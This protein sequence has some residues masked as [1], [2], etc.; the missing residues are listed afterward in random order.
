MTDF[1]QRI[2]DMQGSVEDLARKVPGFKGYFEKQDR[3]AADKLLR[4][5][6]SRMFG[7]QLSEFVRV[8]KKLVDGGGMKHMGKVQG[9]QTR[10]QTL[11]DKID[12]APRGYAG[13]FDSVKV[14]EQALASVYAFDNGLFVYHDQL[15]SGLKALVDVIG[16][17]GVGKVLDQLDD[18]SAEISNTFA[19]RVDVLQGLQPSV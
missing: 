2:V 12:S 5:K 3:R 14:D 10:L 6:L 11:I 4:A 13:L 19:R 15:A 9:I 18:L 8:Q 7:E 1:Y 16:T 17:D